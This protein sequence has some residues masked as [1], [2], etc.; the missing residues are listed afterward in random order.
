MA[1]Y[2]EVMFFAQT[3]SAAKNQKTEP[4]GSV[5]LILFCLYQAPKKLLCDKLSDVCCSVVL[6]EGDV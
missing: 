6:A 4:I 2:A 1:G 5:F 3:Y